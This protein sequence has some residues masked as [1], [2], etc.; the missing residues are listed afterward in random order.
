V[1]TTTLFR[2]CARQPSIVG[3]MRLALVSYREDCLTVPYA[4]GARKSRA[5]KRKPKRPCAVIAAHFFLWL[6]STPRMNC[7]EYCR[8]TLTHFSGARTLKN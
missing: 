5:P 3:V 1:D 8:R 6:S 2:Q 7:F 4:A